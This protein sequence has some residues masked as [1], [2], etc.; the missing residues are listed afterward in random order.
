[1]ERQNASPTF[2]VLL[3][4][5]RPGGSTVNGFRAL[6]LDASGSLTSSWVFSSHSRILKWGQSPFGQFMLA[7]EAIRIEGL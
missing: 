4:F 1:M 2:L 7:P 3:E 6:V 5:F